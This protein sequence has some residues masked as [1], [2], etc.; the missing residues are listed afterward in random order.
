[1]RCGESNGLSVKRDTSWPFSDPI[2]GEDVEALNTL[3]YS[4]TR[5]SAPRI[6]NCQMP[7]RVVLLSRQIIAMQRLPMLW[8]GV[9]HPLQ[10]LRDPETEDLRSL[11]QVRAGEN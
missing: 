3:G 4:V 8:L 1:M 6:L 9:D 10:H 7:S 2:G 11:L 5:E